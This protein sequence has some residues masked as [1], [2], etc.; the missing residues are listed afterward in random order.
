MDV[1]FYIGVFV[2]NYGHE[3]NILVRQGVDE[4]RVPRCNFVS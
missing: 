1:S 4:R 2:R 3:I